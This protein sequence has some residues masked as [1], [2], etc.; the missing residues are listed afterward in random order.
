MYRRTAYKA[1]YRFKFFTTKLLSG[2]WMLSSFITVC[3]T[4]LFLGQKRKVVADH[5]ESLFIDSSCIFLLLFYLGNFLVE[6]VSEVANGLKDCDIAANTTKECRTNI[7][8]QVSVCRCQLN[9]FLSK[10]N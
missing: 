1:L 4:S 10:M 2:C 7:I 6:D 8:G 3:R 5:E 9:F